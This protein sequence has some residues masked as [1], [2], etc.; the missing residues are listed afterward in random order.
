MK[1]FTL[2][3]II[4]SVIL[5]FILGISFGCIHSASEK[6]FSSFSRL[7]SSVPSVYRKINTFSRASVEEL[8]NRKSESKL[9]KLTSNICDAI[10]FT[11]FGIC[12]LVLFYI[13]LDGVFRIYVVTTLICGFF[14]AKKTLGNGFSRLYDWIFKILYRFILYV[15]YFALY[16]VYIT[17][18]FFKRFFI[19]IITPIKKRINKKR[20]LILERKKILEIK[21]VFS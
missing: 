9:T 6:V 1:F 21:K 3:E 13:T 14:L 16:P 19:K 12:S 7:L 20:R 2:T 5:A 11:V 15:E 4:R 17:V 18:A 8:L 10:I